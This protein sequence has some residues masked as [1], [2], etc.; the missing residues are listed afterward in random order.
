MKSGVDYVGVGVGAV[1][2]NNEGKIFLSLRGDKAQN[3][4]D[5]WECPGGT[6]QFGETLKETIVREMREEFGVDIEAIEQLETVDHLIPQDKQHWI[7]ISFLCKI[8]KGTPKILEPHKCKKVGW[9]TIREMEQMPLA[10][11][12]TY[13]LLEMKRK[14][15]IIDSRKKGV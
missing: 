15:K 5:K 6:V 12:T 14:L 4:R 2:F 1:I 13:R 11:P 9:F 7:A 8:T 3:D 10:C